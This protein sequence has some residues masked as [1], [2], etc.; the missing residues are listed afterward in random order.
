MQ[1]WL[2]KEAGDHLS[3]AATN[4]KLVTADAYVAACDVPGIKRQLR[5]AVGLDNLLYT[6][7]AD[8]SCFADLALTSPEDYYIE[9]KVPLWQFAF[10]TSSSVSKT[11]CDYRPST[12]H[13]SFGV[14][15]KV[16]E[17][18]PHDRHIFNL[19]VLLTGFGLIPLVPRLR[20]YLVVCQIGQSLYREGPGKDPFRP[21]QKTPVK[22]FFWPIYKAGKFYFS[23]ST[24]EMPSYRT[25]LPDSME[26]ATLSGRQVSA[27][28]CDAGEE[29]VALQNKI[30]AAIGS[31]QTD[32]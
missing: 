15:M 23:F 27:Y 1:R 20:S 32:S 10:K 24:L 31:Q 14:F 17:I 28:I 21:D 11:P 18:S 29:V 26:G 13:T 5:Q 9:D 19:P 4:K 22:N 6:P 8:F 30:A 16:I 3:K 7:D 12:V 2:E 25:W